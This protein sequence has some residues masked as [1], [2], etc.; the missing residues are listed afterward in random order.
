MFDF[1]CSIFDVR[2]SIGLVFE[3]GRVRMVGFIRS[4]LV[5]LIFDTIDVRY[6]RCLMRSIFDAINVQSSVCLVLKELKTLQSGS[7]N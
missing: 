7:C 6:D 1:R 5:R 2:C 4:G 3:G